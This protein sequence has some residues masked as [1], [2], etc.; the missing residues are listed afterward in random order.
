MKRST[1]VAVLILMVAAAIRLVGINSQLWLD[2][3]W[4]IRLAQTA[5]SPLGVFTLHHDNNHWL[6]TLV[7]YFLGPGRPWWTYHLLPE[8]TGIATVLLGWLIARRRGAAQGIAA[9]ILLGASEFLVEYSSDARGYAPAGFFAMLCAWLLERHLSTPRR[10]SAALLAI[11]A[12]LGLLS[13][14]TFL[15]IF[16]GLIAASIIALRRRRSWAATMTRAAI[17]WAVPLA[18]IVTLFIVDDFPHIMR[19]GGPPTPIDLPAQTAAMSLGLPLSGILA[20]LCGIFVML[21]CALQI[22]RLFRAADPLWPLFLAAF[23]FVPLVIFFLPRTTYLHPRYIY[24]AVPFLLLLLGLELGYWISTSKLLHCAAI[25]VLIAFCIANAIAMRPFFTKGRGDYL[26]ALKYMSAN[27]TSPQIVVDTADRHPDSTLMVLQY[28]AQ[29]YLSPPRP[30]A[31]LHIN[32]LPGQYPQWLLA[33]QDR[34]PSLTLN[35][36]SFERKRTFPTGAITSGI[37]WTVYESADDQARVTPS[38]LKK[39]SG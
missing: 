22:W 1:I 35:S 16:A 28:Y 13:H 7:L 30:L 6:N 8:I 20:P 32:Q 3:I 25:A 36:T 5:G 18:A 34:G 38:N 24:V 2:E 21:I 26:G 4:S 12:I 19:G 9:L 33:E 31:T 11:S 27:T 15:V 39:L 29:Y 23:L 17:W 14:L 37:P 10:W